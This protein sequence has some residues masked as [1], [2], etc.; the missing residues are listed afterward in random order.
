MAL[1]GQLGKAWAQ[2]VTTEGGGLWALPL[3]SPIPVAIA[4]IPASRRPWTTYTGSSLRCGHSN[5]PWPPLFLGKPAP[6]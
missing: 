4:R 6:T 2:V 5:E 3:P 1:S